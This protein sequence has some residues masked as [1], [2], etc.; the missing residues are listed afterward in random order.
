[1]N[2]ENTLT[3]LGIESSCDDSAAA[4]RRHRSGLGISMPSLSRPGPG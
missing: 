2:N 4:I 3:I 1:M